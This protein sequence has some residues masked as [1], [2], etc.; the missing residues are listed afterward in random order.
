VNIR[1][2]STSTEPAIESGD[3]Q[4]AVVRGKVGATTI[5][6]HTRTSSPHARTGAATVSAPWIAN[7]GAIAEVFH[8]RLT[9]TAPDVRRSSAEQRAIGSAQTHVHKS[10][11]R[12]PAVVCGIVPLSSE[13]PI[14]FNEHR[15]GNRER[16]AS[17]RWGV[18][19]TIGEHPILFSA[20]QTENREWRA[21]F[22]ERTAMLAEITGR[23]CADRLQVGGLGPVERPP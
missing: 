10:G 1:F 22:N 8:G 23:I 14:L 7:A 2:C 20:Q 17:A 9:P 16:R 6:P 21:L 19:D 5:R 18:R 11:D 15:T 13:Y 4:P 12:H 3:R